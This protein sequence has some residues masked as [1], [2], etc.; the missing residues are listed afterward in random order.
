MIVKSTTKNEHT[1]V[2]PTSA[3]S[4]VT[5]DKFI[6]MS[7]VTMY[8][9]QKIEVDEDYS[10]W[11]V[12]LAC[13][14]RSVGVIWTDESPDLPRMLSYLSVVAQSIENTEDP[15]EWLDA[16]GHIL[17]YAEEDVLRAKDVYSECVADM[18]RLKFLLGDDSY[19]TLIWY[20]DPVRD[21][22]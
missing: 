4:L 9:K 10:Y 5:M 21:L 7:G 17:C 16:Y 12:S 22:H 8:V 2:R 15:I 14:N 11:E 19:N 20:V 13:E 18:V 1:S 3:T 6:K